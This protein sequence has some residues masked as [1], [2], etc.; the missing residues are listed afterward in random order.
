MTASVTITMAPLSPRMSTT[1]PES[2]GRV[3]PFPCIGG[4]AS[5][6][7]EFVRQTTIVGRLLQTSLQECRRHARF[8][9]GKMER[10]QPDNLRSGARARVAAASGP[11]PSVIARALPPA[12]RNLDT[13]QHFPMTSDADGLHLRSRGRSRAP[14]VDAR[15]VRGAPHVLVR[16]EALALRKV[17]ACLGLFE[18]GAARDDA[19]RGRRSAARVPALSVA[20]GR[21]L[22]RRVRGRVRARRARSRCRP[23]RDR[24]TARRDGVVAGRVQWAA[25]HYS[26]S[27]DV[28][29]DLAELAAIG[30]SSKSAR[31][32]GSAGPVPG[33]R[34]AAPRRAPSST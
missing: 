9:D 34:L 5:M 15:R 23:R 21:G 4:L 24:G 13:L 30:A 10:P 12:N 26:A 16:P 14:S 29:R 1:S 32:R 28:R 19:A 17:R 7:I 31:G 25:E 27:A 20:R 22:V 6:A 3:L 2:T 33:P 8:S 18:R 11:E